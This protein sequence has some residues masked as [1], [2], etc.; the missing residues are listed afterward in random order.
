MLGRG[1]FRFFVSLCLELL[2]CFWQVNCIGGF[3]V[4][5]LFEVGWS[6]FVYLDQNSNLVCIYGG[7]DRVEFLRLGQGGSFV[8]S[9][10]EVQSQGSKVEFRVYVLERGVQVTW[11]CVCSWKF[12]SLQGVK[13]VGV[14][15]VQLEGFREKV[16]LELG[17]IVEFIRRGGSEQLVGRVSCVGGGGR[18]W[19][20]S[21]ND[22][23]SGGYIMQ[24]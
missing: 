3:L 14:V 18:M 7:T 16:V 22:L 5:V 15:G 20:V 23:Q 10:R 1:K 6:G 4:V 12:L 8:F 11:G 21:G 19:E 17:L 24:G 9:Y 13:D 2:I